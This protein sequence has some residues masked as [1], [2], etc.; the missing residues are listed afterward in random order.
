MRSYKISNKGT[1]SLFNN[2]LLE[3]LTRTNFLFPLLLYFLL[4]IAMIIYNI[5]QQRADLFEMIWCIP[6]GILFFTL[7]E[8]II[9]RFVF[10]FDAKNE[11][12]EAIKFKMHGVHHAYPRDK[13]RLAMPP[14]IS[15]CLALIFYGLFKLILGHYVYYF[16][17]GFLSGY[18]IY[19][20]IH[21]S[22][23][24]FRPPRN[25]L[26][27]LWTHHALHHYKDENA[28]YGVSMP[29]WDYVFKTLPPEK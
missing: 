25:F 14:V 11:K 21:Y 26:K 10:H 1:I 16:F 13:E 6:A 2:K 4:S 18:S 12:Q 3:A 9:H 24:R 15:I 19:L 22:I 5:Y 17:P 28:A 20:L 7:I 8:Y 29:L 27:I 23:H